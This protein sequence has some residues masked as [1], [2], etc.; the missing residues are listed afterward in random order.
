MNVSKNEHETKNGWELALNSGEITER[1]SVRAVQNHR[2]WEKRRRDTSRKVTRAEAWVGLAM[3]SS[4]DTGASSPYQPTT[5]PVRSMDVFGSVRCDLQYLRS[6]FGILKA[7]EVDL[8]STASCTV[9]FF[10]A[11]VVLA[12]LNHQNGAEILAVIYGFV[13]MVVYGVNTYLAVQRRRLGEQCPLQASEYMRARTASRG[14][15]ET[16]PELQ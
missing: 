1:W 8:V 13:V 2:A 14:E 3:R 10:L 12:A 9:S 6:H 16:Q 15:V 4:E 7:V 5:E 11:S